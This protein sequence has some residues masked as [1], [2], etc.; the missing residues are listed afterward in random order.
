MYTYTYAHILMAFK[1]IKD[2]SN[3]SDRKVKFST[4][5]II[6]LMSLISKIK[7]NNQVIFLRDW[8][9]HV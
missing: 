3:L 7:Y 9:Y 5:E 4:K 1:N 2:F 8:I 6:K